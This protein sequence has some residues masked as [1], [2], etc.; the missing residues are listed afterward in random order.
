MDLPE[1]I[2]PVQRLKALYILTCTLYTDRILITYILIHSEYFFTMLRKLI[3]NKTPGLT[4]MLQA[5]YR[6]LL[7]ENQFIRV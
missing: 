1:L 4:P 5:Y 3:L 6:S 2:N 7:I